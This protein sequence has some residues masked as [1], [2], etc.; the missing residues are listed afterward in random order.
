MV[1]RGILVAIGWPMGVL[2]W[3]FFLSLLDMQDGCS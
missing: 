1:V 2:R 3:N